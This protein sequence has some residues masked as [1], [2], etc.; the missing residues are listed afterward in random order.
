MEATPPLEESL[1]TIPGLYVSSTQS[2]MADSGATE[3]SPHFFEKYVRM[4]LLAKVA[5][6]Q[7]VIEQRT[8]DANNSGSGS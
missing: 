3:S 8:A 6:Q 4:R 7:T 5:I 2:V 1:G